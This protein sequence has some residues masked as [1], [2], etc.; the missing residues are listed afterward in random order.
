VVEADA[1]DLPFPDGDFDVVM[2]CIGAM[3][4]PR[5]ENVAHEL[6]RVCRPDGTIGS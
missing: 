3:F 2:S 1:E 6:V 4:A 5:H